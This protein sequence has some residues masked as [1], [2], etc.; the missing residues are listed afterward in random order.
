[1]TP[2]AADVLARHA[3][4]VRKRMASKRD[5]L[6]DAASEVDHLTARIAQDEAELADCERG[7]AALAAAG[8]QPTE[9]GETAPTSIPRT[10]EGGGP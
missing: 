10:D 7:L 4:A 2:N 9:A 8:I 1:M 5:D 3:D 6:E